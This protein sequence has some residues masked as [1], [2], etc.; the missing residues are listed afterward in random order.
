MSRSLPNSTGADQSQALPQ[1]TSCVKKE[2]K[3]QV[4]TTASGNIKIHKKR[5]ELFAR[6]KF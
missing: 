2:F 1:N 5:K 6:F 4:R 3:T